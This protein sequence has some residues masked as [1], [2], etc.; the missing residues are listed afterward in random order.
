MSM[1]TAPA[2]PN[3]APMPLPAKRGEVWNRKPSQV[4]SR[5]LR[6]LL[7]M[8]LSRSFMGYAS[9]VTAPLGLA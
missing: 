3:T 8:M 6:I 1:S 7:R 9:T 5:R 4:S 2:I